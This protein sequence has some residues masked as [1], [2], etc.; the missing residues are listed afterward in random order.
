[1][2]SRTTQKA[3]D[4]A[5]RT[6]RAFQALQLKESLRDSIVTE[7]PNVRWEDVAGLESAKEELH[8]AVIFPIR[9]PH[10]YQGKRKAR[11]G[12]LLYGPPGTGKSYLAKAVATECDSTLFSISSSDVT[13]KWIGESEGLVRN[14]FK[15]A[16]EN[17]PSIIFIDEIDALAGRRDANNTSGENTARMKTEFL[18]QM[19]GVGNDN[20][21]VLVLA[22]T[23][24]PWTLDPAVRRRFQKRIHIPLPDKA[25]RK[26][27]F[28]IDAR[29]M[30]TNMQDSDF[31]ELAKRTEGFSGSDIAIVVDDVRNVP[32]KKV[33]ATTHFKKVCI[34]ISCLQTPCL[35]WIVCRRN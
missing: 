13:S 29:D 35:S 4:A 27:L 8:E 1:M 9:F 21:G 28:H 16:R 20:E 5:E 32:I 33:R 6:G 7:K 26:Q 11:R 10:M 23:N 19:D 34:Q 12:I 14:L 17:R 2:S 18:V 30:T 31:E 25:A 3:T 15:L 24:L 22:A